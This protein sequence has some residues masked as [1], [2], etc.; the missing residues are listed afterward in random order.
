M[1]E[2]SL[3]DKL[4]VQADGEVHRLPA[5][6][7]L[8]RNGK[9]VVLCQ[10][11]HQI[12]AIV[13]PPP[14]VA[15]VVKAEGVVSVPVLVA[16]LRERQAFR[17]DRRNLTQGLEFVG[18]L[19]AHLAREKRGEIL[20]LRGAQAAVRCVVLAVDPRAAIR[21]VPGE[22]LCDRRIGAGAGIECLLDVDAQR[23]AATLAETERHQPLPVE[24]TARAEPAGAQQTEQLLRVAQLAPGAGAVLVKLRL[25]VA[26]ETLNE[27]AIRHCERHEARVRKLLA[28]LV[29]VVALAAVAP[30]GKRREVLGAVEIVLPCALVDDV[31]ARIAQ[32]Q[33]PRLLLRHD[34]DDRRDT[35]LRAVV[36]DGGKR[37][38]HVAV[39]TGDREVKQRLA[40]QLV[41]DNQAAR[42]FGK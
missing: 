1:I 18:D 41:A 16:Q 19:E 14:A 2:H 28:E 5:A 6:E 11:T 13:V 29:D 22:G 24:Q 40:M 42:G 23:V 32:R 35:L 39:L 20:E 4:P 7:I 33:P 37:G 38:V 12:L 26:P 3:A 9:E 15:L 27:G 34:R 17:L 36:L 21:V 30:A 10:L 8:A 31:Y 25:I